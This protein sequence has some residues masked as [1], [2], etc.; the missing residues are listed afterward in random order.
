MVS[1]LFHP[2]ETMRGIPIYIGQSIHAVSRAKEWI[3]VATQILVA[4]GPQNNNNK[5]MLN[6]EAATFS[7]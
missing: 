5:T 3:S 7:K 2:H 1:K 4:V 6:I